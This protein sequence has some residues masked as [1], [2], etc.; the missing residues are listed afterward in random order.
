MTF[1][2]AIQADDSIIISAD[3]QLFGLD[4]HKDKL[5]V[6]PQLIRKM[7]LWPQGMITATGEHLIFQRIYQKLM[8]QGQTALS[9]GHLQQQ[10]QARATEIGAHSQIEHSKLIYSQSGDTHPQLYILSQSDIQSIQLNS[11]EIFSVHT[12]LQHIIDDL[13]DLQRSITAKLNF[14]ST[15]AWLAHY[16]EPLQRIYQKLNAE[17]K[18]ISACFDVYFQ[19]H[20]CTHFLHIQAL[21]SEAD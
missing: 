16:L 12:D 15:Q 4:Q 19:A 20:D 3:R 17:D 14:A 21:D 7:H 9:V 8:Q 6:K 2:I 10:A 11:I 18:S 5:V 1:I 13:R